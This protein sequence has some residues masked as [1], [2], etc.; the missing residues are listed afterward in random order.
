MLIDSLIFFLDLASVMM[1][2]SWGNCEAWMLCWDPSRASSRR[3]RRLA[4]ERWSSCRASSSESASFSARD[5]G[6]KSRVNHHGGASFVHQHNWSAC[7]PKARAVLPRTWPGCIHK[8]RH[9]H[10]WHESSRLQFTGTASLFY[11]TVKLRWPC[12][13]E[14]ISSIRCG[15]AN[16][17][18]T[19]VS[20]EQDDHEL[21]RIWPDK[22]KCRDVGVGSLF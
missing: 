8:L 12:A 6:L 2:S 22:M 4:L 17:E 14:S 15:C 16:A 11:C 21:Q 1:T 20:R 3:L 18:Y 9:I 13:V 7:W 19:T 5:Y 10:S